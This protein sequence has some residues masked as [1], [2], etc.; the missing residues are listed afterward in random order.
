QPNAGAD[1][2]TQQPAKHTKPTMAAVDQSSEKAAYNAAKAKA[3]AD[4]KDA[5][6]KCNSEQGD[7]MR[8]CMMEA[9][10]TRTEALALAKSQWDDR[11]SAQPGNTSTLPLKRRSTQMK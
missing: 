5:K 4:Y 7:A 2:A 10:T 11:D 6:V 9:K 3:Q 1:S 8:T